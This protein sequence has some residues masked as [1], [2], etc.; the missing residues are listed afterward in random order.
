M[1]NNRKKI[2][3]HLSKVT[4]SY[5]IHHE[6]PTLVEKF[7][8]GREETFYAVKNLSL[9][10]NAGEKIGLIGP[11]GSG[12]T[13]LLKLIAGI[14]CPT[15][16]TVHTDGKI[17]SLIDLEAGFHPDL[18]GEQNIFL[19]GMIL[20]MKRAEI[21]KKMDSI[22]DFADIGRFIDSPLFSYSEGMKL[23]LGFSVAAHADPDILILDESIYAGDL[24]F[25]RK[26]QKKLDEFFKDNKTIL[27]VTHWLE[28]VQKNCKRVL[29]MNGGKIIIDGK[30]KTTIAKYKQ[31]NKNHK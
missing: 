19:N 14:T 20:G 15:N 2:A 1:K 29:V 31:M 17:V 22:I 9:Q 27:L 8:R 30:P 23:K 21:A 13:T 24:K 26:L 28:F 16:G 25:Q 11:N 7:V 3:V 18:T 10:I 12:K 5:V 6:K 4:K